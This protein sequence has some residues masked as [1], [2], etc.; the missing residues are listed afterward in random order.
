MSLL[1]RFPPTATAANLEL[2]YK[3]IGFPSNNMSGMD[4]RNNFGEMEV[5]A[6]FCE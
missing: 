5:A 3:S 4:E 2:S 6:K 1:E